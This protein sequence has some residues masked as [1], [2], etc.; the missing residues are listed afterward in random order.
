MNNYYMEVKNN[1]FKCTGITRNDNI[2]P[3]VEFIDKVTNH[4]SD[5]TLEG[6]FDK[7]LINDIQQRVVKRSNFILTNI[8]IRNNCLYDEEIL[9]IFEFMNNLPY[10][11]SISLHGD[12]REQGMEFLAN[13]FALF[14]LKNNILS[15]V[16]SHANSGIGCPYG[17]SISYSNEAFA[18]VEAILE[19]LPQLTRLEINTGAGLENVTFIALARFVINRL[20]LEHFTLSGVLSVNILTYLYN[21]LTLMQAKYANNIQIKYKPTLDNNLSEIINKLNNIPNIKCQVFD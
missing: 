7:K 6:E 13:Q 4:I 3:L 16:L 18:K 20:N 17:H 11:N 19:E 15:L 10:L 14:K 5:L 2:A 8:S 12:F 9:A 21:T 1:K